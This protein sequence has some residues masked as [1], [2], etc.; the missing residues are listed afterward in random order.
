MKTKENIKLLPGI[1]VLL[2]YRIPLALK[3]I[4]FFEI[5]EH[6]H[7]VKA[8]AY[9]KE[10]LYYLSKSVISE[11]ISEKFNCLNVAFSC[12]EE[13]ALEPLRLQFNHKARRILMRRKMMKYLG[14]LLILRRISLKK[15]NESLT[16]ADEYKANAEKNHRKLEDRVNDYKKAYYI[17]HSLEEK[18]PSMSDYLE[19]IFEIMLMLLGI[20]IGVVI[21]KHLLR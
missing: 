14:S 8:L 11:N 9:L 5:H 1:T 19:R 18:I 4:D 6:N 17:L 10:C 15:I 7:P 3:S 13:A 2:K 21:E 16:I 20:L 12:A